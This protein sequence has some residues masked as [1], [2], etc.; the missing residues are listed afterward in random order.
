MFKLPRVAIVGRPNVGKS[1]LFNRLLGERVAIVDEA[2]GVTRDRL[3]CLMSQDGKLFELVDTGGIDPRSQATFNDEIR[4]QSE[5]A[6]DES[7][8]LVLVVNSQVGITT[9]DE[10]LAKR[11][12]RTGKPCILAV[13]KVDHPNQEPHAHIFRRLGIPHILGVS[14]QHGYQV[15]ELAEWIAAQLPETPEEAPQ[16]GPKIALIGRPN[17]GKSTLLNTLLDEKRSIV[18]PIAGTTRDSLDCFVRF[19]DKDYT[20]I[21][22]AGIRRKA[23]HDDVVEKFAHIR[24]ERAIE[25][26]D[27]VVLMLDASSGMTSQEKRIAKLIEERG[28]GCVLFFNKWDIV[29]G[30]RMEHCL[31]A[32]RKEVPFLGHCPAIFGSAQTGRNIEKIF[33]HVEEILKWRD[34]RVATGELNRFLERAIQLNHPPML[35]GKRLRIYYLTQVNS[36]PPTFLLFVNH[37]HLMDTGWKRYLINK[38]REKFTFTGLPLRF[39]LRDKGGEQAADFESTPAEGLI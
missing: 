17:V 19:N 27:L 30:F 13:N 11:M 12:L 1:A 21:D 3:I 25:R 36:N 39:V 38:L 18:S 16:M 33:Q 2:E 8:V 26:A 35:G 31:E 23:K 29:K 14:A 9:L 5:L 34:T 15:M 4:V 37:L 22:T 6:I 32:V 10:Q 20:F 7:D 24:T 28:K